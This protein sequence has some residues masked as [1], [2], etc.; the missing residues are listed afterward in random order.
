[1]KK[2]LRVGEVA[3]Q[4]GVSPQTIRRY[5]KEGKIEAIRSI[6]NC[7]EEGDRDY[8]ASIIMAKRGRGVKKKIDFRK[9]KNRKQIVK[10]V[11]EIK[12]IR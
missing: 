6:T 2:Y 8:F 1:M 12:K 10:R 4:L 7:K 11:K 3:T 9:T 5:E